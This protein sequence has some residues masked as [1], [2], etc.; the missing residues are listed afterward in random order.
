MTATCRPIAGRWSA[1][2]SA[3]ATSSRLPA[4]LRALLGSAAT[5][6]DAGAYPDAD[7]RFPLYRE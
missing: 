3:A 6:P 5:S 2:A 7:G 1:H 4:A